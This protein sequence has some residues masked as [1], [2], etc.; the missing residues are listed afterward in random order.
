[1]LDRSFLLM[2]N[3][4]LLDIFQ[5]VYPYSYESWVFIRLTITRADKHLWSLYVWSFVFCYFGQ[6]LKCET[7]AL[8][9]F[10]GAHPSERNCWSLPGLCFPCSEWL[11]ASPGTGAVSLLI[12]DTVLSFYTACLHHN[13]IWARELR[14]LSMQ[15]RTYMN[16]FI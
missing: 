14:D 11:C 4:S 10:T 16:S 7:I 13:F 2:N 6:T 15:N 12:Y 9:Y 1:M 3:I 5:S 8:L